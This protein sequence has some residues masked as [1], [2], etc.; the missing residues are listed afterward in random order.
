MKGKCTLSVGFPDGASAE[1]AAK[2]VSHERDVGSR[3]RAEISA[4]GKT[5]EISM[6]ADDV[7][8]MRASLNA[9][10]RALQVFE[11]LEKEVRK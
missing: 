1:A 11:G 5:L 9:Y 8:A 6:E 3:S 2:A 4:N 7:T 10:L